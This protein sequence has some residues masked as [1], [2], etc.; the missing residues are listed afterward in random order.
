MRALLGVAAT[1]VTALLLHPL[2]SA[3]IVAC[4]LATL[5][6]Y[7]TGLALSQ[8][9]R[10]EAEDAVRFGAD[11]YVTGR[12][13]G[14]DVPV[15]VAAAD[16][17]R[18][19]EG[20]EDVVPR[21]VGGIELGTHE[22]CVLVGVP[23]G[24]FPA[25]LDCVEGRPPAPGP[26]NE[27]VV[28]S[29]LARRLRLRVGDR[30]PPFYHNRHGDRLSQVVGVFRSDVSLWQAHLVLTTFD[31]AAAVFD[32]EGV[33]T[34]LLVYCRTGYADLVRRNLTRSVRLSPPG[35]PAPVLPRVT[36]RADLEGLLPAGLLHREGVFNLLF[37][38]AFAVAV[39]AVLVSSGVGDPGRR[40]EVGVLKATGWQ[41]DEILLRAAVESLLLCLAAASLAVLLAF[42]WLEWLNGYGVA[43]L[44]LAGVDAAPGFKV[45]YRLTP[46]PALLALLVSFVIVSAGTLYPCWR[47]ATVPPLQAIRSAR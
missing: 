41:T 28:G 6:P 8:G 21:I 3:A 34:D 1:G 26:V 42:V 10:Q 24:R 46:V 43:S 36:T 19:L 13:F 35:A 38:V 12:Q 9:V 32:Q 20:V 45:P 47:A 5:L 44:F 29:E 22:T 15:P 14:R 16:E 37:L 39:L 11:V 30:L 7:L 27:L 18:K 23:P 4:V 17:V 2:R 31:S 25:G 33:A 40:R